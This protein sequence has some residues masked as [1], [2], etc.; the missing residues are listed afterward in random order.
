MKYKDWSD[1]RVPC[2]KIGEIMV[3]PKKVT[4]PSARDYNRAA[5][6]NGKDELTQDD[7][8]LLTSIKVKEA[9][10]ANPEISATA[11]KLLI[12]RYSWEKYNKRMVTIDFARSSAR[13]GNL[14]EED[15]IEIV[16]SLDKTK[17]VKESCHINN[18]YMVGVCDVFHNGGRRIIDV[19]A[20]WNIYTFMP[21]LIKPVERS[22]WYQAQGYMEL[23][24][25]DIAE[26]CHVLVNTPPHLIAREREKIGD[27]FLT[28]EITKDKYEEAME[29]LDHSFDYNKIPMKR[30]VIRQEISRYKDVIPLIYSKVHKCRDWLNEF[31]RIHVSNH[32]IIVPPDKY[33]DYVSTEE[34]NLESDTADP[35]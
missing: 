33:I 1:W 35:R 4:L 3:R 11:I 20:S 26:V 29:G 7:I 5:K 30:R 2:S 19:K 16:S 25:A 22:Y 10:Y 32:K 13:K 14:M 12:S 8:D 24:D 27:R 15:A 28:G 18:D 34:D 21:N 6:L 9:R 31:E 17:Y 23:Y